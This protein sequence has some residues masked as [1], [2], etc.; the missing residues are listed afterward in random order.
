M[1][2][3]KYTE[4]QMQSGW[5]ATVTHAYARNGDH[6]VPPDLGV[7]GRMKYLKEDEYE[8]RLDNTTR[9]AMRN[10][11]TKQREELRAELTTMMEELNNTEEGRVA[12]AKVFIPEEA[13]DG[14][15]EDMLEEEDGSE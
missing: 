13:L 14:I 12:G 9:I 2:D 5:E 6:L 11:F 1:I 8:K 4:E 7:I 3:K 10:L 15:I